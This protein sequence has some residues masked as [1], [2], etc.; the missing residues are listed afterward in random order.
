MGLPASQGCVGP[1]AILRELGSGGMGVVHLARD[2]RLG[3]VSIEAAERDYGVVLDAAAGVDTAATES[4]R[5]DAI[6]G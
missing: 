6:G 4:R 3:F 2:V 1:Y 5:R